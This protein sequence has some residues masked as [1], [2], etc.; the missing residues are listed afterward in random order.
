M[1][2]IENVYDEI[3]KLV[4]N[5]KYLLFINPR[6]K[7]ADRK[8]YAGYKYIGVLERFGRLDLC[9]E[10]KY[11]NVS[12]NKGTLH[13]HLSVKEKWNFIIGKK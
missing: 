8:E 11:K 3:E 10:D 1:K 6:F 2:K 13:P 9:F 12:G 5:K 4:L 7:W